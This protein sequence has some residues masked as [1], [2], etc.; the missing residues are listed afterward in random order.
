MSRRA[1][2]LRQVETPRIQVPDASRLIVPRRIPIASIVSGDCKV[3]VDKGDPLLA[4]QAS[5]DKSA[6]TLWQLRVQT[7]PFSK[8]YVPGCVPR[9]LRTENKRARWLLN[10]KCAKKDSY[11]RGWTVR[12]KVEPGKGRKMITR[13]VLVS[14]SCPAWRY[15]GADYNA[16]G[17]G[18]SQAVRARINLDRG[19]R[20]P[21][22][23]YLICKHVYTVGF[24]VRG[25]AVPYAF[26]GEVQRRY[27][28]KP[29]EVEVEEIEPGV[30]EVVRPL[31]PP[32]P[33]EMAPPPEPV[34]EAEELAPP[35]PE[36]EEEQAEDEEFPVYL[37]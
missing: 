29:V 26:E 19:I 34:P 4:R 1:E 14:C 33:Q 2:A 3:I 23:T 31:R 37:L 30:P 16:A 25:W 20:D 32:P 8:Q 28:E 17:N 10:V 9:L 35:E 12:L 15:W 18:Y 13:D 11:L 24:L 36:V 6:I 22:R 7:S 21:G 5:H 27:R